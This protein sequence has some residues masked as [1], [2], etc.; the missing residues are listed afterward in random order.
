MSRLGGD[1]KARSLLGMVDRQARV[2]R[3]LEVVDTINFVN[4]K[5]KDVKIELLLGDITNQP[6]EDPVDIIIVSCLKGAYNENASYSVLGALN[7]A[8][9]VKTSVLAAD[10]AV[11][12]RNTHNCW[13]SHKLPQDVPYK[14]LLCFEY[15]GRASDLVP[16][17]M[18]GLIDM[19]PNARSIIMPMIGTNT[20]DGGKPDVLLEAIIRSFYNWSKRGLG[21]ETL[22]IV[23]FSKSLPVVDCFGQLKFNIEL[24]R[25]GHVG[26]DRQAGPPPPPAPSGPSRTNVTN[27]VMVSKKKK[28]KEKVRSSS[29]D[30]E[31]DKASSSPKKRRSLF[32]RRKKNKMSARAKKKE[33]EKEK[34]L[35]ASSDATEEEEAEES[36]VKASFSVTKSPSRSGKSRSRA[37][38]GSE[39]GSSESGSSESRSSSSKSRSRSGKSRSRSG[40]SRSRSGKSRSR[41]RSESGS[42]GSSSSRSGPSMASRIFLDPN[43][44]KYLS[45][46]D[47]S[48]DADECSSSEDAKDSYG[49]KQGLRGQVLSGRFES[50]MISS[51]FHSVSTKR[52][53]ALTTQESYVLIV[54]DG[55]DS[56]TVDLIKSILKLDKC[57][58]RVDT[59]P[60]EDDSG[61]IENWIDKHNDKFIS[62]ARVVVILSPGFISNSLGSYS[63]FLAAESQRLIPV[64]TKPVDTLPPSMQQHQYRDARPG[65]FRTLFSACVAIADFGSQQAD[66]IDFSDLSSTSSASTK[67][68]T[69]SVATSTTTGTTS[70]DSGPVTSLSRPDDTVTYDVFISYSQRFAGHANATKELLEFLLP[71]IRV[72][73]DTVSLQVG[74]QWQK[75]LYDSLDK[76][77]VILALLSPAF[78]TSKFCQDELAIAKL[79]HEEK[80]GDFFAHTAVPWEKLTGDDFSFQLVPAF[81]K[82]YIRVNEPLHCLCSRVVACV[83]KR[84][85]D[86][87]AR[88]RNTLPSNCV[89]FETARAL[90]NRKLRNLQVCVKHASKFQQEIVSRANAPSF[91]ITFVDK[92]KDCAKALYKAVVK[93]SDFFG[94]V[95]CLPL[96][97][98][99]DGSALDPLDK[100]SYIVIILS[101]TF[102]SCELAMLGLHVAIARNRERARC[103]LPL[104]ASPLLSESTPS[105]VRLLPALQLNL[106]KKAD[107]VDET[108]A[109]SVKHAAELIFSAGLL[110]ANDQPI[111]DDYYLPCYE[112]KSKT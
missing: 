37:R 99:A 95:S 66:T 9:G 13:L 106:K 20:L 63:F 32:F 84:R 85:A 112:A 92:D 107:L 69:D 4:S 54:F 52:K 91:V 65:N 71:G 48:S 105:F 76:S 78:F 44:A 61:D 26:P 53:P 36:R 38:S 74:R 43:R 64:L 68:R 46:S 33:K 31:S 104:L 17:L 47:S 29:S 56:D 40:K 5:S 21:I 1:L 102:C 7:N 75:A 27:K 82:S 59:L 30:Q 77:H 50:S 35:S 34:E 12:L 6:K 23:M 10:K 67:T 109:V 39:S 55:E 94:N 14:Q 3:P 108:Q 8:F 2:S 11:D 88:S 96:S 41:A 103:L 28:K 42:S 73:V 49:A 98:K 60:L 81:L 24:P 89:L 19:A 86:A 83:K 22:K 16:V 110:A 93:R 57:P 62:A 25:S 97:G 45:L 70:T 90:H 80:R 101:P 100:C 58:L 72:F 79:V 111:S 18:R 15:N 87:S 51:D